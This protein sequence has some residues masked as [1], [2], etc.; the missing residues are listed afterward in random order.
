MQTQP[1]P[2]EI[3][4]FAGVYEVGSN[5][6][7]RIYLNSARE[8]RVIEVAKLASLPKASPYL[9]DSESSDFID[10][11]I[12]AISEPYTPAEQSAMQPAP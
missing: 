5:E 7:R 3:G 6:T 1:L 10:D 2:T 8:L 12:E 4:T 9:T 11:A